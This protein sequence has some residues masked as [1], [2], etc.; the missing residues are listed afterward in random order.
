MISRGLS[1]YCRLVMVIS[2]GFAR[3]LD[4]I[5]FRLVAESM[6]LYVRLVAVIFRGLI[7]GHVHIAQF[8]AVA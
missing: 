5:V 4:L 3:S 1:D 8:R 2:L 7:V 6:G